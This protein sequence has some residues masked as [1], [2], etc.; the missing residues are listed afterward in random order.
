[1]LVLL[2]L[3][4]AASGQSP[5][6]VAQ[7]ALTTDQVVAQLVQ[8]NEDRAAL[9]KHY[10]SCRYYSVDY[11]GFPSD[12]SAEMLVDMHFSAPAQKEFRILKQHGSR[13]LLDHVLEELIQTE[14]EALDK[15]NLGRTDLTPNNYEFR[16]VST[17][18]IAGQP[19]YVLD[20]TP[21]FKSKFLYRGKIWVDANDFAVTRVSAQPAKSVSFWISHTEIQHEYKKIGEF[22]LPA[23]NTS[24]AHVRFGGTARLTIDYRDYHI[25]APES[26]SDLDACAQAAGEV[27]LSE[28]P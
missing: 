14:K 3:Q 28:N 23:R 21:R 11:V 6:P 17:D 10:E 25:G 4:L 8:R 9:L 24:V 2:A 7:P 18:I 19:Q 16:L 13:L 1:M 22:W 20:V 5:R 15:P 12:K 26:G 27:Q